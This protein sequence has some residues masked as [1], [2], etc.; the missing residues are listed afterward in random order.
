VDAIQKDGTLVVN[1]PA[2]QLQPEDTIVKLVLDRPAMDL[3]V[4]QADAGLTASAS[5]VFQGNNAEYGPQLAFDH[6]AKTRWATDAG[7]KQAWLAADLGHPESI[8]S[9]R[10]QEAAPYAGRVTKFEFQY[11]DGADWKTLFT[12]TKLGENF[13]KSF[14]PVKAREFRLNIL[15]ATEGPTISEWE[16][17][18][19]K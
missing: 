10:L 14:T 19:S 5:N 8:G 1:I 11:K 16:L 18:E 9:V 12:G 3:P 13:N 2:A 15:D 17:V 6:D 4:L 7:T